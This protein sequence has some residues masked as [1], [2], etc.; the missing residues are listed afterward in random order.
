M[1]IFVT[2]ADPTECAKYLDDKRVVKMCLETAQM[3]STAVYISTGEIVAYKPSYVNHPCNIWTRISNAN[4]IWLCKH[5]LALCSEYTARYSRRH[6]SQ[7]VID[8]LVSYHKTFPDRGLSPFANCAANNILGINYKNEINTF[9]SYRK[10]IKHRW[11]L[12]TRI[13]T[14]YG[15]EFYY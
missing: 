3:L 13:P 8:S 10:Y 1:N 11:R 14:W 4:F 9:I 12:D 5:G 6:K 2:S 15:M 7:D